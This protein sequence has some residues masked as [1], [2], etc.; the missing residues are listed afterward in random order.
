MDE[1]GLSSFFR[2]LKGLFKVAVLVNA[3]QAFSIPEV[4]QVQAQAT[5]VQGQKKHL[6]PF[7]VRVHISCVHKKCTGFGADMGRE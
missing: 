4:P 2:R 1:L 5:S 3:D 7:T 6:M